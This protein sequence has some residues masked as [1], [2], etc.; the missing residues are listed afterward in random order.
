MIYDEVK[1]IKRNLKDVTQTA[2]ENVQRSASNSSENQKVD[3]D[4]EN[5]IKDVFANDSFVESSSNLKVEEVFSGESIDGKARIA[6][7]GWNVNGSNQTGNSLDVTDQTS[8]A[9]EV[10]FR[11]NG[12]KMYVLG[13]AGPSI[14]QYSLSGS[15]W[16]IEESIH[17]GVK[18]LSEPSSPKG[19][20]FKPDGTKMYV[21][22]GDDD[23]KTSSLY[24]YDLSGSPWDAL[25][26]SYGGVNL[27]DGAF[28]TSSWED[29]VFR[30]NGERVYIVGSNESGDDFLFQ[31][32]LGTAWDLSSVDSVDGKTINETQA[33]S[34]LSVKKDGSKVYFLDRTSGNIYQYGTDVD[35]NFNASSSENISFDTGLDSPTG[36]FVR[37]DGRKM[38]LYD[39]NQNLVYEYDI[40]STD[41]TLSDISP[42]GE[43]FS[44]DLENREY[45]GIEFSPNGTKF[46]VSGSSSSTNEV[47]QYNLPSPWNV[48]EATAENSETLTD[49]S[50]L[51]RKMYFSPDGENLFVLASDLDDDGNF[52]LED[53]F[54]YRLSVPFEI[55][56]AR[57]TGNTLQIFENPLQAFSFKPDGS[58][59]YTAT[60]E[61]I[62]E[63][64]L[65]GKW[66]LSNNT[67]TENLTISEVDVT[68]EIFFS[69]DGKNVFVLDADKRVHQYSFSSEWA[70]S[71]GSY[72]TSYPLN[73]TNVEDI[74][75]KG[76]QMYV[77]QDDD[78]VDQYSL[79]TFFGSASFSTPLKSFGF[80][81]NAEKAYFSAD[82]SNSEYLNVYLE[83]PDENSVEISNGEFVD[84]TSLSTKQLKARFEFSAAPMKRSTPR[85]RSY[86][87]YVVEGKD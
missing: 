73:G 76:D 62:Q 10:A 8:E 68:E 36:M 11:P 84:L 34:S 51:I 45:K 21:V 53:V 2:V 61:I 20:Y 63:Y 59:V 72:V 80:D 77:L 37:R 82:A 27:G 86:S 16:E 6:Y 67:E 22:S 69:P 74:Y 48:S 54:K 47:V 65:D 52:L 55:S 35:W 44:S 18:P 79:V 83:D 33:V 19:F 64:I 81:G 17:E 46:Y 13:F 58:Y 43:A 28:S 1:Q 26:S 85:L 25:T 60:D 70:L 56:T 30:P 50:R 40:P 42:E 9:E 4:S 41:Y 15:P 78:V 49:S 39:R 38:H 32:D 12:E 87:V 3:L 29:V 14:Q 23:S 66:D 31:V 24:Q 57:Y 5:A 71:T 75:V 7:Q